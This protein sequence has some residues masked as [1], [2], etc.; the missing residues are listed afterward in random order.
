MP[1]VD[2]RHIVVTL[3]A[4]GPERPGQFRA[5][6]PAMA[7]EIVGGWLVASG[8]IGALV[9]LPRLSRGGR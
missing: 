8:L 4:P 2:F 3:S 6:H 1:L 5:E 9:V 7:G